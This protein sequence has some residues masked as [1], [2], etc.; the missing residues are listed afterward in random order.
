MKNRQMIVKLSILS[1]ALLWFA[2]AGRAQDT[3]PPQEDKPK[4]AAKTY[5]P[6]GSEDQDQNQTPADTLQPDERPLTGIQQPTVG[7]PL[8]RHSYWVPGVSYYNLLQSNGNTQGG[9]NSWSSNNYIAGN[10]S[11]LENWSRSQLMLNYSGGGDFSTDSS[12]GNSWFQ[13]FSAT[14]AFNW[15]RW[16]LTLL[17]EF[18][19]LPQSQFGFG[20]GTGLMSPGIGGT[21]GV[22]GTGLG[23]Q[24]NPGQSIFSAIGPRYTNTAGVQLNYVLS[25]RSS[26]TFGGI[27][28]ILRFRDPGNIESNDYLGNVGY[29]YQISRSDTI[30]VV[31]RYSSYHYIGT[32]EAIGDQ[33][34][35]LAYGRKITGRLALQLTG[36][37]DI[38]HV[39]IPQGTGNTT[40]YVAGTGSATLTYALQKG[41]FSVNYFHGVTPGSGVFVGATTDQVTAT[42]SRRL[43]RVWSGNANLGFSRNQTL[44]GGQNSGQIGL[45]SN[46]DTLYGGA[47]VAR[48]LGRNANFSLGYTAYYE[49]PSGAVCTGATCTPSFTTHQISIGLSWHAHPFVLR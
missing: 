9:G 15:E 48:A 34:I 7:T 17:D 40:R 46:Y 37:P 36:G 25:K 19:Y 1:V 38:S 35:Q 32:P 10:V 27:Y 3:Q 16:Q 2:G 26:L 28:S 23:G 20:A 43:T 49:K 4:P 21:L 18:D 8:E 24:F 6:I 47:S 29:N 13:Q 31:Y 11:L 42:G 45:N 30:G 41:S 39:R 14:Q 33:S 5:G 22:P 12:V 44:N